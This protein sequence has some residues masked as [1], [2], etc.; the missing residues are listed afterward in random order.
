MAEGSCGTAAE[1]RHSRVHRSQVGGGGRDL[2][3]EPLLQHA[4]QERF[5]ERGCQFGTGLAVAALAAIEPDRSGGAARLSASQ[6]I[7]APS[8]S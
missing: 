3:F 7:K 4:F 2:L 1:A 5:G 8:S 6:F